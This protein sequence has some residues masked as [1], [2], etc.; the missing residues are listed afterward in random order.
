[1]TLV[2]VRIEDEEVGREAGG[3]RELPARQVAVEIGR[4]IAGCGLVRT[5][6]L[7]R[8]VLVQVVPL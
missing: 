6:S 1:L 5:M 4:G 8:P 7:V 2:D 3:E